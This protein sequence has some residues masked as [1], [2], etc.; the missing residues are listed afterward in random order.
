MS[1]KHWNM[2]SA[3]H[4]IDACNFTCE[5]GPLAMNVA[6]RWIKDAAKVGPE[7]WPG[8]GVYFEVEAETAGVKMSKWVHFYIVG[9]RMDSDS[10]NRFWTYDLS[11]D[12]PAPWHYGKVEFRNIPGK[13]LT[14]LSEEEQAALAEKIAEEDAREERINN[15]PLG[16]GA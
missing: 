4:Q 5:A 1:K 3:L 12:P 8:Q 2:K 7:F 10:D 11:R 9:C 6:Y 15:G 13:R 14:L 16:V